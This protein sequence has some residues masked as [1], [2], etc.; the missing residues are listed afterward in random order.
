[1]KRIIAMAGALAVVAGGIAG[2]SSS[3]S[4]SEA[5][6][7]PAASP[8]ESMVGGMAACDEAAFTKAVEDQLAA[9][10]S[11]EKLFSIDSFQCKDGWAVVF[12][13]VG[14]SEENAYTITSVLQAEGQFWVPQDR[15]KVCGTQDGSSTARP[16]DA[17]VPESIYQPACNTN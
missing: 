4:S 3:S 12:P 2:C 14:A 7:S 13:T 17:Q 10:G 9:E 16:S 15:M 5:A 1:M 8:A 11:G 6:A